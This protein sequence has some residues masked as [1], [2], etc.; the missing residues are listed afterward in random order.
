MPD[1]KWS[2]CD[3]EAKLSI[4]DRD[5]SLYFFLWLLG[6]VLTLAVPYF[7]ANAAIGVDRLQ[8]AG[9]SIVIAAILWPLAIA[10]DM[11]SKGAR[12]GQA[13]SRSHPTSGRR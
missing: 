10:K 4:L 11:G 8:S 5:A 2:F 6:A 1:H 12:A 9:W 7:V 13:R 3:D